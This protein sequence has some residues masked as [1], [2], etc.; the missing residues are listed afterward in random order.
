MELHKA[1]AEQDQIPEVGFK[2]S[3][4][5]P[6]ETETCSWA[7]SS[8]HESIELLKAQGSLRESSANNKTIF[9]GG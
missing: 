8:Y 3:D 9:W 5:L 2:F 7:L 4:G 6:M 1:W